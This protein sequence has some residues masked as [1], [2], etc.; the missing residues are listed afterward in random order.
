MLD[1]TSFVE[2]YAEYAWVED[3][4]ALVLGDT[5]TPAGKYYYADKSDFGYKPSQ[6]FIQPWNL[7][8]PTLT[9]KLNDSNYLTTTINWTDVNSEMGQRQ[10]LER[11]ID[12]KDQDF[13]PIK[14]YTGIAQNSLLS[15]PIVYTTKLHTA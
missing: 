6:E 14:T 8:I 11:K 7:L 10:V 9:S 15:L 4:R 2:R 13:V 1:T 5:L 12:G 3:K